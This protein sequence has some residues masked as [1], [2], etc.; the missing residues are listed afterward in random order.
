MS[1]QVCPGCGGDSDGKCSSC[2]EYAWNEPLNTIHKQQLTA[3]ESAIQR[4][5]RERDE[6]EAAAVSLARAEF[7]LVECLRRWP[8]LTPVEPEER[9]GEG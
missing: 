3:D 1:T 5:T 2:H 4:L 8:W 6:R 9:E 7:P